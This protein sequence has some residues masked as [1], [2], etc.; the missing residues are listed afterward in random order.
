MKLAPYSSKLN[1]PIYFSSLTAVLLLTASV[2]YGYEESIYTAP[3]KRVKEGNSYNPI[4]KLKYDEKSFE[5]AYKTFLYSNNVNDA[6]ALAVTAVKQKP[7]LLIWRERLAQTAIWTNHPNI[8]IREILYL[9]PK[10]RG[11]NLIPQAILL[12][13][14]T[15]RYEDLIPILLYLHQKKPSDDVISLELGDAYN[16][17][18]YPRAAITFLQKQYQRSQN[19]KYLDMMLSIYQDLGQNKNILKII[20]EIERTSGLSEKTTL[21]RA[22][23]NY[24]QFAVKAAFDDLRQYSLRVPIKKMSNNFLLT[25]A[26]LGWI[27]GDDT[28]TKQAYA[29]LYQ[30]HSIDADGLQRLLMLQPEQAGHTKLLLSLDLWKRYHS[31]IGFFT[32]IEQAFALQDWQSISELYA[33]PLPVKVRDAIK[34]QTSY[35]QIYALTLQHHQYN[36]AARDFMLKGLLLHHNN[37]NFQQLYLGFLLNQA[38]YDLR[39]QDI[40]RLYSAL[41]YFQNHALTDTDWSNIYIS[42]FTLFNQPQR[43]GEIYAHQLTKNHKNSIFLNNYA[44]YLASLNNFNTAF[45]IQSAVWQQLQLDALTEEIEAD[46]FWNAY[47]RTARLFAPMQIGFPVALHLT[48]LGAPDALLIWAIDHGNDELARYLIAY[49]YPLGAPAWA[50]LRLA[51]LHNDQTKMADLI[52]HMNQVL[53]I[54]D[55]IL[56]AQ[57]IG[58][59]GN[60]Q[61]LA[62]DGL[63]VSRDNELFKQFTDVMLRTA[64]QYTLQTEYEQFGNLQGPRA[65]LKAKLFAHDQLSVSPFTSVWD[66]FS[67]NTGNLASRSYLEKIIGLALA[68]ETNRWVLRAELSRRHALYDS[69]QAILDGSYVVTSRTTLEGKLA[70]NQ[71]STLGIYMLYAGSQDLA[72]G[73]VRYQLTERD[74]FISSLEVDK[75]Y[76]QDR[77]PLGS[78]SV[79]IGEYDHRFRFDYPDVAIIFSGSINGFNSYNNILT[80]RAVSILPPGSLAQPATFL[81]K[82]FWQAGANLSIGESVRN[83]YTH[84]WRPY[85]NTGLFYAST[86]G[87]GRVVDVG[88]GGMV[89]GRDKLNVSFTQTNLNTGQSQTNFIFGLNYTLYL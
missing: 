66:A 10:N 3:M 44:D 72:S 54:K 61:S 46:E 71:R 9:L 29:A 80:G 2:S 14:N 89:F 28:I 73:L 57:Q 39:Q 30:R 86:G 18:G 65:I 53:P 31:Q 50:V 63:K 12:A 84:T 15:N 16:K 19:K 34:S 82:G 77:T 51:I 4:S 13:K 70:Y 69:Y 35:W 83:Q 36:Q 21:I 78:G 48:A 67:N 38:Q 5:L 40:N 37:P 11:L 74:A 52:H 22:E 7:D 43:V 33:A 17:N 1:R 27:V 76:L 41:I 79:F 58:E 47:A 26:K 62:Y 81:A 45:H 59:I 49:D 24:N 56:A 20:S 85:L 42:A 75:F 64:D 32:A 60:A 8:A 88:Y 23:L 6:Y 68:R 87:Y 55:R 25:Q